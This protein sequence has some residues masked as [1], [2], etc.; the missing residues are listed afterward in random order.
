MCHKTVLKRLDTLI[1]EYDNPVQLDSNE[2]L[3]GMYNG[4]IL[5]RSVVTGEPPIF[6][7]DPRFLGGGE[8]MLPDFLSPGS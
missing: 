6:R 4:L 7:E 5:A 8:V 3:R 2:Y 1:G